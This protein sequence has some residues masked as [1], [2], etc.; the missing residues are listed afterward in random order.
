MDRTTPVA[1]SEE[2]ELYIRTYYSL[3][4]SSGPVRVRSLE[5][6][7]VAMSSSLHQQAE[8]PELDVS[9]LS[10]SAGRL[11]DCMPQT[12]LMIMGQM[13][14]VFRREGYSIETWQP[15]RARARRRKLY[16]NADKHILAAFIASVSDIDDLIPCVTT[17]Q[18]EWNKL[19]RKLVLRGPGPA[20]AGNGQ[21][22]RLFA[23]RSV[24]GGAERAGAFARR[25]CPHGADLAGSPAERQSATGGAARS[26]YE[27]A[28]LGERAERLSPQRAILVAADRDG[29]R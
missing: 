15:I 22:R 23:V 21:R 5:E 2:I 14:D 11:P 7:H 12:Q 25:F 13:E 20:A 1:H 29:E 18:I 19:H 28:R 27:G 24:G 17:Y 4:R 3:L 6:T 16:Y 9:A 8:D 10:Y 26:G